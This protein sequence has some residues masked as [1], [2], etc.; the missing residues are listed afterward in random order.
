MPANW[1]A[2][3]YILDS[4]EQVVNDFLR[5]HELEVSQEVDARF[6][7]G[8]NA[9]SATVDSSPSARCASNS[10]NSVVTRSPILCE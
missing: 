2:H 3:V 6:R 8:G 4:R 10:L 5:L 1:Q 9:A 7:R